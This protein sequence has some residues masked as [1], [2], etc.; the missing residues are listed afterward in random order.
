MYSIIQTC[1]LNEIEPRAYLVY[2]FRE[3]MTRKEMDAE[4]AGELLPHKISGRLK[5]ELQLK[6]N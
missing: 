2:Y 1:L 4:T 3:C 5:D 6:K